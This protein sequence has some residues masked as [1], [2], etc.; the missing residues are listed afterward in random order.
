MDLSIYDVIR[1]ARATPKAYDL[2]QQQRQLVLEIHPQANKPM[3]AEALHKLFNVRPVS[4][5]T[6]VVKGRKRRFGR[7]AA[8]TGRIIKKAIVTLPAGEAVNLGVDAPAVY[9]QQ[10]KSAPEKM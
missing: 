6:M 9:E 1:R 4:I 5:R 10:V 2:N 7:H 8:S 3:V